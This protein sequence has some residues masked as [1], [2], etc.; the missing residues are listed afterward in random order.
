MIA[1]FQFL[2]FGII[3]T[4]TSFQTVESIESIGIAEITN[5]T[6]E[7][8]PVIE[9]KPT[10]DEPMIEL[11]NECNVCAIQDPPDFFNWVEFFSSVTGTFI[12]VI[13]AY[14][15]YVVRKRGLRKRIFNS[16]V[17]ELTKNKCRDPISDGGILRGKTFFSFAFESAVNSGDFSHFT[18]N[19][20]TRVSEIY[21]EIKIYNQYL[22]NLNLAYEISQMQYPPFK[23]DLPTRE[24][25]INKLRKQILDEIPFVIPLVEKEI[26]SRFVL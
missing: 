18:I 6:L 16:I 2:L 22:N 20:Q 11:I 10:I 5:D 21:Q 25:F 3:L 14:A 7:F 12:G 23:L 24:S 19:T 26:P 13:S 15:F 4:T 8:E 9:P 17:D 1:L